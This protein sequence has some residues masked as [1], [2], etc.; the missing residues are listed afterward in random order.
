MKRLH[1]IVGTI[2]FAPLAFALIYGRSPGYPLR[3]AIRDWRNRR[4]R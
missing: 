2:V 4:G 3:N 1:A